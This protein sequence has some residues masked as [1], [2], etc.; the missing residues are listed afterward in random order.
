MAHQAASNSVQSVRSPRQ[1]STSSSA[2][3]HVAPPPSR[4]PSQVKPR[5]ALSR[6]GPRA[7]VSETAAIVVTLIAYQVVLLAIGVVASRRTSD[8]GDFFLGGRQLG[9]WVASLSASA[10]SSSAW[11]LLGVSGAAYSWGVAA[12]WIFPACVGGF[13][14]NWYVLAS[15][16]PQSRMISIPRDAM[17]GRSCENPAW[18]CSACRW[19]PSS[20]R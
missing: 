6:Y 13:A 9:P 3:R 15:R 1:S 19:R 2:N 20:R 4:G 7:L 17:T 5:R 18:S 8:A 16:R 12:I 14:L 11:T 10:S